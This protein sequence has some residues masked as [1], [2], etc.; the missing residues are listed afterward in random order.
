MTL[1]KLE[2][3]T[4]SKGSM[5]LHVWL[6]HR[7]F[8]DRLRWDPMAHGRVSTLQFSSPYAEEPEIWLPDITTYNARQTPDAMYEKSTQTVDHNGQVWWTRPGVLDL[9]CA[10]SGLVA[11]PY[12]ELRCVLE[13]GGWALSGFEQGIIFDNATG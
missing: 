1:Y 12:D 10:F 6:R 3:V 13:I 7:W 8:D 4:T 11:F 5:R 2:S 9:L